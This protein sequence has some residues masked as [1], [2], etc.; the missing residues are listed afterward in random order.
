MK[1][2]SNLKI[3]DYI[4][5][6]SDSN[7]VCIYEVN[8]I[9]KDLYYTRFYLRSIIGAYDFIYI[10]LYI[11]NVSMFK[12]FNGQFYSDE[13]EFLLELSKLNENI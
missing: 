8:R 2:F 4:Y 5:E 12:P 10:P 13:N 9:E 3:G 7:E 6:I 11:T 1:T